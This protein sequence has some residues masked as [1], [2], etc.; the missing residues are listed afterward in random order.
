MSENNSVQNLSIQLDNIQN[1]YNGYL[2]DTTNHGSIVNLCIA[3]FDYV[4]FNLISSSGFDIISMDLE[5]QTK[6]Y[7]DVNASELERSRAVFRMTLFL[8]ICFTTFNHFLGLLHTAELVP[9]EDL[10]KSFQPDDPKKNIIETIRKLHEI[11]KYTNI[12]FPSIYGAIFELLPKLETTLK[13]MLDSFDDES[14]ILY[15]QEK[16]RIFKPEVFGKVT[17][18]MPEDDELKEMKKKCNW[19]E[20]FKET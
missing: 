10:T 4:E 3:V 17:L 5:K 15:N 7:Q 2:S 12:D 18:E 19:S 1:I 20:A 16:R 11:K 8:T 6:I 9:Q 13:N 14:A